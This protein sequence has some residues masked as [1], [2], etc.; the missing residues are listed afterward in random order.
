MYLFF[1]EGGF[2]EALHCSMFICSSTYSQIFT[3]TFSP[4]SEDIKGTV[5]LNL[6]LVRSLYAKGFYRVF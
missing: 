4:S 2:E 3:M 1:G 6:S 5:A